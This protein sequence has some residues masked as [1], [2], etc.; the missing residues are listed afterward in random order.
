MKFNHLSLIGT[1]GMRIPIGAAAIALVLGLSACEL[2][3]ANPN[4]PTEEEVLTDLAG[5][6]ALAV[7]LQG[8]Y[9]S[10]VDTYVRGS[11]LVSDEWGL[12]PAGLTCDESL[13]TG[14]EIDETCGNISG[15]YFVTYR[16]IRSANN[17]IE[18]APGIERLG[19]GTTAGLVAL[20]KLYKGMALGSAILN[21]E[22]IAIDADV[23]GGV[24]V[25]RDQV[26]DAIL[27]LLESARSDI[28]DVSDADLST[29]RDRVVGDE[30]DVRNTINAMLARYYL[31]DGQYEQAIEAAERV[32]LS[33]ISSFTYPNPGINP[34]YNYSI[35]ADYAAPLRSFVDQAE[36]GDQRPSFWAVTDPEAA[37]EGQ[38]DS[39]LTPPVKYSTRN[40]T[41]PVY[42][43]DEMRLIQ[44]EAHTRLGGAFNLAAA[45]DLINEVRVPCSSA[46]QEPVACLPA[47]TVLD[48]A[49]EDD[50]LE[51]IAYERRYEL[52]LQG[53][54]W[55]DMRRLDPYIDHEPTLEFFPFPPSECQIN[56]NVSC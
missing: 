2:D 43:P 25:P 49:T 31:L 33:E 20:G 28:E 45:R 1:V 42:L 26:F 52:Y 29:F 11:A 21:F 27:G 34:I 24:P 55:E 44:A 12:K 3:L 17:L 47:L 32:D 15:P 51:Q 16:I 36:P 19:A 35:A 30:F 4:A 18:S 39:I 38:P 56:P 48:L 46:L 37:F 41:F 23:E 40:A 54:R 9:A 50:L 8:Q 7:G 5:V 53:L 14:E 13:L 6:I 10:S 22:S